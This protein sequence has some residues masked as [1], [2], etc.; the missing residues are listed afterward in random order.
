MKIKPLIRLWH[1][2]LDELYL[3][4]HEWKVVLTGKANVKVRHKY[5]GIDNIAGTYKIE[6]C[7]CGKLRP[8]MTEESGAYK[9]K[10]YL[11]NVHEISED[12]IAQIKAQNN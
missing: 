3:H 10:P 9:G 2:F 4:K 7:R 1:C 12:N 8:W 6:R 5:G 11:S